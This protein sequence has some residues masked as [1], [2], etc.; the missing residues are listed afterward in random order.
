MARQLRIEYEKAYYHVMSHS[1]ENIILFK[2]EQDYLKFLELLEKY[3]LKFS[4]NLIAYVLMVNHYH[5]FFI[6]GLPNLSQF[7][8]NLNSA[9]TNY[10][11]TRHNHKGHL[12]RGRYKALLVDKTTY[13]ARVVNYIHGNPVKAGIVETPELYKWSSIQN[14]M[15]KR[16]VPYISAEIINSF[17]SALAGWDNVLNEIKE[18]LFLGQDEFIVKMKKNIVGMKL[19]DISNKKKLSEIFKREIIEKTIC[20]YFGTNLSKLQQKGKLAIAQEMLIYF[21]YSRTSMKLSEIGAAV[22]GRG[23]TYISKLVGEIAQKIKYIERYKEVAAYLNKEI[24]S[25]VKV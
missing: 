11:N 10:Y 18:G 5:L 7:M 4:V 23:R 21:L 8:Q 25:T 2:D 13:S 3:R 15:K 12:F 20:N 6:T 19:N 9:Y 1:A 16:S 14:Y 17:S 24:S 22:G